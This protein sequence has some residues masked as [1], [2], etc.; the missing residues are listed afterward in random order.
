LANIRFK[1]KG[2]KPFSFYQNIEYWHNDSNGS[3]VFI[4]N[5]KYLVYERSLRVLEHITSLYMISVKSY[6]K[7]INKVTNTAYNNP[8]VLSEMFAFIKTSNLKDYDN[9]W[10]NY[11]Q[12][13]E[14]KYFNEFVEIYFKSN[15]YLVI[16][17]RANNL[18][19][20]I[21]KIKKVKTYLQL[22]K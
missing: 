10:I 11:S 22:I 8:V 17:T 2:Q 5:K 3:I 20:Q 1:L 4:N 9:H 21:D 16:K 12:V 19:K 15:N 7:Y 13:R 18:V 14:I 6:F